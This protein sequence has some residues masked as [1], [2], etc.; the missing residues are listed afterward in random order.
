[1]YENFSQEVRSIPGHRILAANRGEK[2]EF[3]K[4]GISVERD[5]P[6]SVLNR[7]Y[8]DGEGECADFVR[9]AAEDGYDRLIFPSVERAIRNE[10]TDNASEGA[11]ALFGTNLRQL[12]LQPP[13]KNKVAIGLD[14]GY[15]TGCKVAVVDKTG[16]VLDTAVIYPTHSEAQIEKSKATLIAI[17]SF[18]VLFLFV[19][20]FALG[21]IVA[22]VIRTG[23]SAG[24]TRSSL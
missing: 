2:E 24:S 7:I 17:F 12:L 15:R 13:V 18:L 23:C 5:K 22:S 19:S 8:V 20:L 9:A 16:K 3:L 21:F 4:A 10:L 6:L 11:I 14:P 1:M